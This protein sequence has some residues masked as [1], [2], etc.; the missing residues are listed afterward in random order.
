[1]HWLARAY[2]DRI[3]FTLLFV[4]ALAS[5]GFAA[6]FLGRYIARIFDWDGQLLVAACFFAALALEA[7]VYDRYLLWRLFRKN[8]Q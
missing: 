1:M 5:A 3:K 4:A 7:W 6:Q 2:V 8:R